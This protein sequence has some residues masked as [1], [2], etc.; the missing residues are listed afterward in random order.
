M[1]MYNNTI[2]YRRYLQMKKK[3]ITALL[4][5]MTLTLGT[6]G[7]V[8][9]MDNNVASGETGNDVNMIKEGCIWVVD[10]EAWTE[11]IE[12]PEEGHYENGALISPEEGHTETIHHPAVTEKQWIVDKEAWTETV[13]H[14][15]QGHYE[16]IVDKPAW[17]EEKVEIVLAC[18]N[19]GHVITSEEDR[20][21]HFEEN[22]L[23]GCT[24]YGSKE[25]TTI[26][27]HPAETHEEWVVD[28]EA[29]T[30]T[31]NHPEEGHYEDVVIKEAWDEE[32]WVVDKPAVYE[33][34]WVVDKEAW[35]E[36]IEHPEEGHWEPVKDDETKPENPDE[37]KP[38]NPDQKPDEE[39]S[40]NPEQ[41]PDEET[42]E[43]PEQK[44]DEETP[45]NPEQKPDEET[46]EN[47]EQK[48]DEETPENP[49]QKP[50]A[51]KPETPEQKP[52]EQKKPEQES[53]KED[54]NTAPKTGDPTN[55]AYLATLA[56][57]ALVGGAS[58][59]FRKRK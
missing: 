20:V 28:K 31:L 27:D 2:I 44:P 4:I 19:C 58:L 10:K 57:S 22:Y 32:K 36:T 11:T 53:K 48:P 7:T 54:T 33:Q 49:E 1:K 8:F 29:W 50:D 38:E 39:T 55:L 41:K 56:G 5:T 26:I 47:P 23:N 52:E 34:V 21:K 43:N 12:H 30:E 6:V 42:P 13:N 40:E 25:I 46:P 45:E 17:K 15:E 37:E 16:T 35:T 24:S 51:E 9:A 18:H 59:K 3:V 14:P